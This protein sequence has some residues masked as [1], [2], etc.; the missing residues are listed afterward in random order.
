MRAAQQRMHG[1]HLNA[2]GRIW[3]RLDPYS[4]YSSAVSQA[5]WIVPDNDCRARQ[6]E[7]NITCDKRPPGPEFVHGRKHQSR[8]VGAIS[9]QF[10]I[11]G[12]KQEPVGG[13]IGA[14]GTRQHLPIL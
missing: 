2:S 5:K 1:F 9:I 4:A 7:M 10:C 6:F 13:V 3:E 11:V 8:G 12:L 14:E